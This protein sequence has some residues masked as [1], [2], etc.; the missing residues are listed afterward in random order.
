LT[1]RKEF[2]PSRNKATEPL[3]TKSGAEP[4]TSTLDKKTVVFEL[5]SEIEFEFDFPTTVTESLSVT[6]SGSAPLQN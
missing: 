5:F 6:V 4:F 1:A 3:S 2:S